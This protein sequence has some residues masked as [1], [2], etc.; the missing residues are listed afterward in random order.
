[1]VR[2]SNSFPAY[3]NQPGHA[4]ARLRRCQGSSGGPRV[5]RAAPRG[6][7]GLPA[8]R[9]HRGTGGSAGSAWSAWSHLRPGLQEAKRPKCTEG[10]RPPRTR[11]LCSR[12][13]LFLF[14]F[15]GHAGAKEATGPPA[16]RRREAL[17]PS[18][19]ANPFRQM[20]CDRFSGRGWFGGSGGG[21]N[22]LVV[23]TRFNLRDWRKL[24]LFACTIAWCR[25]SCANR[26]WARTKCSR[27]CYSPD[28]AST[29]H[30][31]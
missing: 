24:G 11:R 21:L 8:G 19:S 30:R 9:R 7:K 13:F 14:F 1:M 18:S 10:G 26:H 6:K 12:C 16:N 20:T 4:S 2:G 15:P 29:S 27:R 17:G 5:T 23:S 28:S 22:S 25:C 31:T 3:R